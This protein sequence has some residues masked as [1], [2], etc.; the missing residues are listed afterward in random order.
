MTIQ[1]EI[2]HLEG[3]KAVFP[4]IKLRRAQ[5]IKTVHA[6]LA[7]EGNTL[8]LAQ[9]SALIEG[10]RIIGPPKDILEAQNAL[11]T[12]KHID[13]LNPFSVKDFLK[14]HGLM[15]KSLIDHSGAFRT[16]GVGIFKGGQVAHVAPPA[17]R[18]RR[19][20]EDLF[21]FVE[22]DKDLNFLIKSCICHY[23]LEF[24]H[25]FT[26]GN[27]RIGR[28]WQQLLLMKEH[29]LFQFIAIEELVRDNQEAYYDVLGSC[30]K[31]GEST[32]FIVFMLEIVAQSL[33]QYKPDP[34]TLP[35]DGKSRLRYAHE[36][37]KTEWFTRKEYLD[38]FPEISTATAS[39][40]LKEGVSQNILTRE[41]AH[42]QTRY[43]Y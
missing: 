14:A 36:L 19:L 21:Q 3:A 35:H 26:D 15:M 39:R 23:E 17:T 16:T 25:P 6:S 4:S 28:L 31:K 33:R 8:S 29:S 5:Q 30:D 32:D 34:A 2:G 24:I 9:I 12:Y 43:K 7:I 11:H 37:F 42:N 13:V 20:I 38:V 27:G 22:H 1:R 41:N 40:D 10:K 18:V